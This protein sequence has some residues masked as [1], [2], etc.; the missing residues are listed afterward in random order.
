ML[1]GYD[2]VSKELTRLATSPYGSEF[3][4]TDWYEIGEY[5]YLTAVVQV[6]LPAIFFLRKQSYSCFLMH[7][8]PGLLSVPPVH[9][10]KSRSFQKLQMGILR[11]SM[12]QH[13]TAGLPRHGVGSGWGNHIC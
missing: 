13:S 6:T 2:Y 12:L 7:S 4:S 10:H 9:A 11:T 5:G 3:T 8:S 1:W